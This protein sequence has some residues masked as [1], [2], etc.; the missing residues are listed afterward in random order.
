MEERERRRGGSDKDSVG[1]GARQGIGGGTPGKKCRRTTPGWRL[2][3]RWHHLT[4]GSNLWR[5]AK[6]RKTVS[7]LGEVMYTE[8][9]PMA[10]YS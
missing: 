9:G 7:A 2:P 5:R 8:G 1:P 10:K 6:K 4:W 3:G